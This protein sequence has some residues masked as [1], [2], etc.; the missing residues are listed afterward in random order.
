[1]IGS[2]EEVLALDIA[3]SYENSFKLHASIYHKASK[4]SFKKLFD[5]QIYIL[6][7]ILR[8]KNPLI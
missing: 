7:P 2:E 1:M 6:S 4:A 8:K 3:D 5:S